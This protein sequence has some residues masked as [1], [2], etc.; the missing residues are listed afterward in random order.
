MITI[1]IKRFCLNIFI[2]YYVISK[3]NFLFV[4]MRFSKAGDRYF[5]AVLRLKKCV[6]ECD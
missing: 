1:K 4:S 5:H 3:F 2:F 6:R